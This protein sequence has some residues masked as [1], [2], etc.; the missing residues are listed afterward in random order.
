MDVMLEAQFYFEI[1]IRI[2]FYIMQVMLRFRSRKDFSVPCDAKLEAVYSENSL[3]AALYP[4]DKLFCFVFEK[5]GK[6]LLLTFLDFLYTNN[7]R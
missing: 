4:W 5:I 2:T 3:V 6:F 7:R 1:L